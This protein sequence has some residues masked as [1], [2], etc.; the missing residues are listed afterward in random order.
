M[1]KLIFPDNY[2]ARFVS[3]FLPGTDA[4]GTNEQSNKT[5]TAPAAAPEGDFEPLLD[6]DDWVSI[7]FR[8][9]GQGGKNKMLKARA[10]M[11]LKTLH[12]AETAPSRATRELQRR[13][14]TS[15]PA[16]RSAGLLNAS[17]A[18]PTDALGQVRFLRLPEVKAI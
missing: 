10:N 12:G 13:P 1:T 18:T 17:T 6:R 14:P 11:R 3:G 7:G 2:R 9:I 16:V 15:E 8:R 4:R 5:S